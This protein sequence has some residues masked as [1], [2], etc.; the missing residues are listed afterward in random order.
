VRRGELRFTPRTD[1]ASEG[2]NLQRLGTLINLVCLESDLS[3]SAK[4]VFSVLG[5]CRTWCACIT[6]GI[7]IRRGTVCTN[8]SEAWQDLHLLWSAPDVLEDV[9]IDVASDSSSEAKTTIDAVPQQL[10]LN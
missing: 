3:N 1:A 7:R 8:C 2:L 6:C 5:S 9:W 10:P 4:A